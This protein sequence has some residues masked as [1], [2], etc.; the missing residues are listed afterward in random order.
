MMKAS[1]SKLQAFLALEG[2]LFKEQA[3]ASIARKL[4]DAR[5][6]LLGHVKEVG[7]SG[8]LSLL[9][10][11]EKA[12]VKDERKHH[13]NSK[14][15]ISSLDAAFAELA[16]VEKLLSIVDDKARYSP[17]DQGYSLPRNREKGLP[18]DE[19]RQAFRS[20]YV[21]LNNLDRARLSEYEKKIIDAR[22]SN[23]F[24]AGK[25]Y[26]ERQAKTLGIDLAQGKKRGNHL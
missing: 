10:A 2:G 6:N 22:K 21:R 12:I 7:K 11:T 18:L 25:L 20:H 26:V 14:G 13:A 5:D 8:D 24:Q 4:N 3:V 9:V 23:M 19:A 17:I 1:L 15:M 16:A